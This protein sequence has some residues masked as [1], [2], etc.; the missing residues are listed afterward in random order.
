M[1]KSEKIYKDSQQRVKSK[2]AAN[3][4]I[5]RIRWKHINN[6][7]DRLPKDIINMPIKDLKRIENITPEISLLIRAKVSIVARRKENSYLR[8]LLVEKTFFNKVLRLFNT[9]VSIEALKGREGYLGTVGSV[10]ILR[11][12][13]QATKIDQHESYKELGR[14]SETLAPDIYE[15]YRN[16][17]LTNPQLVKAMKP[18]TYSKE[19]PKLPKW[20]IFR[21]LEFVPYWIISFNRFVANT[22]YYKLKPTTFNNNKSRKPVEFVNNCRYPEEILETKVLGNIQKLFGLLRFDSNWEYKFETLGL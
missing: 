1:I 20:V 8:T 12:K 4:N 9:A 7:R 21:D 11:K 16:G 15:Q 6:L 13:V 10:K 19:N 5:I 18:Y 2:I 3:S 14:L 17:K 22:K